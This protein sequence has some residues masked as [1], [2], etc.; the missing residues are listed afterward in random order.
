MTIASQTKKLTF[1]IFL[2][3]AA[4]CYSQKEKYPELIKVEGGVISGA[5]NSTND[6]HIYKG[7]PFAAPPVNG[8]RWKEPQPVVPWEGIKE[9]N[10]FSASPM[11]ARPMCFGVYT[12]EFLI[13]DSPISEDCLYLNVW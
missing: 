2:L 13:P 7:I 10:A 1:L 3:I 8:L 4:S 5:N 11:Q 9:C 6:I 12:K